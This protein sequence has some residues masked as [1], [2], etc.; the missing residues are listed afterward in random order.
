MRDSYFQSS[1]IMVALLIG[2][3]IAI[4]DTTTLG[5]VGLTAFWVMQRRKQLGVRRALGAT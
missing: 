1:R 2:V 4:F 5:I 3:I